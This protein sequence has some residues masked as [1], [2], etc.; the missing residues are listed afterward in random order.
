MKREVCCLV[1]EVPSG[2]VMCQHYYYLVARI[3][4]KFNAYIINCRLIKAVSVYT[5]S[6][7]IPQ[8]KKGRQ[9]VTSVAS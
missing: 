5:C 1:P 8:A 9:V 4:C 2:R 7:G 6:C 3:A